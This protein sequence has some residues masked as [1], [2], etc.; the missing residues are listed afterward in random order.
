MRSWGPVPRGRWYC[1][2]SEVHLA[3]ALLGCRGPLDLGSR[4]DLTDPISAGLRSCQSRPPLGVRPLKIYSSYLHRSRKA[5]Q[6]RRTFDPKAHEYWA[7]RKIQIQHLWA[8]GVRCS[9]GS[10]RSRHFMGFR[11]LSIES[12]KKLLSQKWTSMRHQ[13]WNQALG[14]NPGSLHNDILRSR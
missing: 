11:G 9:G 13:R 12:A 5:N 7:K 6:M 4:S 3:L 1:L 14:S 10:A 2:A 8:S